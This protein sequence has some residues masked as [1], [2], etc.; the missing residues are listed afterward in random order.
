MVAPI[1]LYP[2]LSR[3][4][5]RVKVSLQSMGSAMTVSLVN[6]I[7]FAGNVVPGSCPVAGAVGVYPSPRRQSS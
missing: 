4:N 3:V 1:A 2:E 7:P 6:P 5:G